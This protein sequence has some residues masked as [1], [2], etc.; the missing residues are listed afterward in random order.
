MSPP[1]RVPIDLIPVDQPVPTATVVPPPR[2]ADPTYRP[3]TP[4]I[5]TNDPRYLVRRDPKRNP[6]Q[7]LGNL[8]IETPQSLAL[9][10]S[11]EQAAKEKAARLA[12]KA[13]KST[14]RWLKVGVQ[15]GERGWVL[16]VDEYEGDKRVK[17]T[18]TKGL[19]TLAV[20]ERLALHLAALYAK[21]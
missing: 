10:A 2:V 8:P 17:Q 19:S 1:K 7:P 12:A 15:P 5:V 18:A 21:F 3:P 6:V 20:R 14:K 4:P 16:H 11:I 9:K 13:D